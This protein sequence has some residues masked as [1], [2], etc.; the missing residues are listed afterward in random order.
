MPKMPCNVSF[1]GQTGPTPSDG[2]VS[3][4]SVEPHLLAQAFFTQPY[5]ADRITSIL[6]SW[7]KYVK[8]Q[9]S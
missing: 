6:E 9:L 5:K 8:G 3:A 7:H 2:L 1:Q 4:V